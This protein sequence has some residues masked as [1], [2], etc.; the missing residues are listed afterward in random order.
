MQITQI[1]NQLSTLKIHIDLMYDWAKQAMDLVYEIENVIFEE[2]DKQF[3]K[4]YKLPNME[5]FKEAATESNPPRLQL[6]R[7]ADDHIDADG[8]LQ[9]EFF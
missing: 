7:C 6:D 9:S 5:F 4:K 2:E 8:F 1:R 3:Y